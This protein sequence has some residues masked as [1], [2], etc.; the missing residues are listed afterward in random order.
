MFDI[1]PSVRIEKNFLLTTLSD[2]GF[3]WVIVYYGMGGLEN[4]MLLLKQTGV[5]A[6]VLFG[7]VIFLLLYRSDWRSDILLFAAGLALGYW[8][9]WWGTTRGVW[10]YWNGA[11]PPDYLP[12]LW[13]LGLLTVYRL[14]HILEP[15]LPRHLP[16][17]LEGVML[18][19]FGILP[20]L[21][22][23]FSWS[24]LVA[25]DWHGRLDGHFLAGLVTAA[26]LLFFRFELRQAFLLY[27]CGMLLGG[28]YEYLGTVSRE[29]VYITHEVP[30]LWIIPLWGVACVAMT[31]L[32]L[33]FR[34]AI[35]Q[36]WQWITSRMRVQSS[37]D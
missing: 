22:I 23:G 21:G 1:I 14:S 28:M 15:A 17:W 10:T 33:G 5:W 13:G 35:N 4:G 36:S 6:W 31:H 24:T 25:V 9:E 29:W 30:P 37:R 18:S 16:R 12:P 26:V 11:M 19:S 7:L 20:I 8:G 34:E 32:S 2:L 27:V 3:V